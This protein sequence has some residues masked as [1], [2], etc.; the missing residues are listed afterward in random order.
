MLSTTAYCAAGWTLELAP[1]PPPPSSIVAS[2]QVNEP[3][4]SS[5]R[6]QPGLSSLVCTPGG[7][8]S[9]RQAQLAASGFPVVGATLSS[10]SNLLLKGF[11]SLS[12]H[13]L[14]HLRPHCGARK[15]KIMTWLDQVQYN[16]IISPRRR[17]RRRRRG[18]GR[19][20]AAA[21]MRAP[22]QLLFW[23][24]FPST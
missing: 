8:V 23:A 1:P 5:L 4:Y 6:E 16:N 20:I 13:L 19:R 2:P 9:W 7:A 14:R 21:N 11:R 17:L 18:G 3:F 22:A 24:S 15:S 12:L 10:W